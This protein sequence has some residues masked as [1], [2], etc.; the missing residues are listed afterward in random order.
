MLAGLVPK[1]ARS[2]WYGA[3]L[4]EPIGEAAVGMVGVAR[5]AEALG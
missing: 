5:A 2:I 4:R 1:S 3:A